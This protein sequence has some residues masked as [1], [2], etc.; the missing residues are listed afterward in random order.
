[1]IGNVDRPRWQ[2]WGERNLNLRSA[3]GISGL[4]LYC[5]FPGEH[6]IQDVIPFLVQIGKRQCFAIQ[7][8]PD[9]ASNIIGKAE[10]D[11]SPDFRAAMKGPDGERQHGP[12]TELCEKDTL[13]QDLSENCKKFIVG[14]CQRTA[15]IANCRAKNVI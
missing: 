2:K 3:Y 1:M 10:I 7:I 13:D 14:G 6:Q 5:R 11:L 12:R 9:N 8:R 4:F 15:T